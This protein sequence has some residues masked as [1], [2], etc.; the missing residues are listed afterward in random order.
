MNAERGLTSEQMVNVIVNLSVY[1]ECVTLE[2]SCTQWTVILTQFDAFFRRLPALLPNPTDMEPV[3]KIMIAVLKI[4]GLTS[5]KVGIFY[6]FT[7][8]IMN[9]K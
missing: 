4:P 8:Y 5:V 7:N 2:T 9:F 6:I 3:F 1:L